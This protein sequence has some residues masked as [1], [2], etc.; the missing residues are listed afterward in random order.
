MRS[1]TLYYR[2]RAAKTRALRTSM[3]NIVSE[4]RVSSIER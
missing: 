1:F 4:W 3:G 2:Q